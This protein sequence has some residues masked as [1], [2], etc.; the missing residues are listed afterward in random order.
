[1]KEKLEQLKAQLAHMVAM[2]LSLPEK[3]QGILF[4]ES[5]EYLAECGFEVTYLTYDLHASGYEP[6][7]VTEHEKMFSDEGIPIKFLIARKTD[8]PRSDRPEP[9]EG[10]EIDRKE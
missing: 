2:G 1:M 4:A 10:D 5:L 8:L 3:Q 9:T 6:N 7:I